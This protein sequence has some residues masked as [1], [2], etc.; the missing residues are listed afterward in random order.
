MDVSTDD[1]ERERSLCNKDASGV[2]QR[3][4]NISALRLHDATYEYLST[5]HDV[6][7]LRPAHLFGSGY[8]F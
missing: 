6:A 5:K 3:R 2:H 8:H 4:N 1:E 7:K